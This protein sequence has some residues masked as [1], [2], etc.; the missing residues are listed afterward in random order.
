MQPGVECGNVRWRLVTGSSPALTPLIHPAQVE[1]DQ[2]NDSCCG[3][4][5]YGRRYR[6]GDFP[7]TRQSSNSYVEFAQALQRMLSDT[8]RDGA[9][10]C[11]VIGLRHIAS[12]FA[13]VPV[14]AV[15]LDDHNRITR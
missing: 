2:L 11:Q 15:V 7:W 6:D 9:T 14:S 13:S 5:G 12:F 10:F 3:G 8:D 4:L 1:R